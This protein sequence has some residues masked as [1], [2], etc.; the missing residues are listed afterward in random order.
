MQDLVER[1]RRYAI[2][3]HRRIDHRRKYTNQPYE[4]H[5][6]AVAQLVAG[7]TDD[8]QVIAAAWLHDTVEDT[9]VT[10]EEVRAEFGE[11]VAALVADLT[12]VSRPSDGNRAARKAV[13]RQ[14]T[15]QASPRAKTVKL[16]DLI[17]NCRDIR[18]GD[19]GFARVFFAEASA[20]LPVLRDGDGR[21]HARLQREV[22][23]GL[24]ELGLAPA[25][26]PLLPA[27]PAHREREYAQRRLLRLF[28]QSVTAIDLAEALPWFELDSD[29]LA[30]GR[31]ADQAGVEV[32][33]LREGG[34]PRGYAR[35]AALSGG[36]CR[37]AAMPFRD[38]QVVARDASLQDVVQ[39]LTRHDCCFVT[40]LGEVG[41]VVRREHLNGPVARM[42]LFGILTLI[43][44]SFV[45]RIRELWA[46]GAWQER[47]APKRLEK[48]RALADERRRRGQ[49]CDLLDCLQFS[50]K[51][52][53]LLGDPEERRRFAYKSMGSAEQA[54]KDVESLRNNLAHGQDVVTTDWS[55]IAR[56][57]LQLE[58]ILTV[59]P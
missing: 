17:D 3:M 57:A 25:A 49:S 46:E 16:A 15:A 53:L 40:L 19:P 42:W 14:H 26:M 5:L 35:R 52:M 41:G 2:A 23:E 30:V 9:P 12:D 36:S 58:E 22:A 31:A 59:L 54:I 44:M 51:A 4:V 39:V 24:R 21:L 47:L 6:K 29:A 43:E 18:R 8:P 56:L 50:D 37:G 45:E 13:D 34:V 48:A 7:V 32:V 10:L 28:S 11:A 1:A 33:G 38:D 55:A 20:L 27:R